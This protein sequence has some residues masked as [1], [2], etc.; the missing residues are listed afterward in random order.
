[1]IFFSQKILFTPYDSNF[2]TQYKFFFKF[3]AL[4]KNIFLPILVER[5]FRYHKFF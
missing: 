2:D 3:F 4:I 5:I 1:M